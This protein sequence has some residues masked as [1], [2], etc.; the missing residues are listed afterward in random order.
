M[1]PYRCRSRIRH[2]G[3]RSTRTENEIAGAGAGE[4]AGAGAGAGFGTG[5]RSRSRSR[6]WNREQE[7]GHEYGRK[8]EQEQTKT[9]GTKM[10]QGRQ[11][12]SNM[13]TVKA[14]TV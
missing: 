3:R 4:R 5:S 11:Q 1:T 12:W 2:G 14:R 13:M 7:P 6:V 10:Q 9:M 8:G